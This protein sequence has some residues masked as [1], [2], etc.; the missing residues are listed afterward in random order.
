MD[1]RVVWKVP[2]RLFWCQLA[3]VSDS[4]P[5]HFQPGS[6]SQGKQMVGINWSWRMLAEGIVGGPRSGG[7]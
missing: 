7:N 6:R 4:L 3:Q 5:Q 2:L 1:C